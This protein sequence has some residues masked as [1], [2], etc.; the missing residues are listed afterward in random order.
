MPLTGGVA[1]VRTC[2]RAGRLWC[3][4]P[5]GLT[6][7]RSPSSPAG[8]RTPCCHLFSTGGHNSAMTAPLPADLTGAQHDLTAGDYTAIVTELGAGLRRLRYRGKPLIVEY[9][10]DQLPPSGA[11]QLLSPWPNRIDHGRYDFGGSSLQ[12]DLSEPA[13]NNAIHGLTRWAT[14]AEAAKSADFV[15]LKLALLGRPGYPFHLELFTGYQLLP[16]AGLEVT[17][18]ARNAGSRPAPYGTG[19]HPYLTAGT[20]FVDECELRLPAARRQA[21]DE[22]G[23]PVGEPTDVAGTPTDFRQPRPIGDLR[24]D[25]PFTGLDRDADG[26]ALAT[27]TGGGT[28]VALW[29]GGGYDWLQV[30]TGDPLA[31]AMRRRALAVEPMTCPANAFVTGTGL[32]T[33]APGETV[34]HSWGI[35]I[36]P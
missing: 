32:I 18:T 30:F 23:I 25:D 7:P 11:G 31:P 3:K 14:W 16:T 5:A 22:R 19:S 10:A 2:V 35:K 36:I 34:S 12:L 21:C 17:I 33:L 15:Q 4:V 24:L 9:E 1:E 29:A 20:P 13:H 8:V 27:L 28:T 6:V 26:R